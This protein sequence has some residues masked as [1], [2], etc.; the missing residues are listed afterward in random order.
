MD[1]DGL[2]GGLYLRQAQA[3]DRFVPLGM[4]GS[5]LLSDYYTDRKMDRTARQTPVVCDGAGPV[6][7]PGGTV[8]D[9]VKIDDGTKRILHII[10]TKGAES[11]AEMGH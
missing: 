11:Y 10:F 9:R 4:K 3:G 1:G 8:A 6:F 2:R 5:K 7:L